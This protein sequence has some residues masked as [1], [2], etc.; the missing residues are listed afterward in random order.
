MV[1]VHILI[2]RTEYRIR[3]TYILRKKQKQRKRWRQRDQ[4][5]QVCFVCPL[6]GA[7]VHLPIFP[8]LLLLLLRIPL[9]STTP[10]PSSSSS[11]EPSPSSLSSML[12][13]SAKFSPLLPHLL[14]LDYISF[15]HFFTTTGKCLFF[16]LIPLAHRCL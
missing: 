8:L 9:S 3:D 1:E 16:H 6:L 12:L 2:I 11:P 4:I 13:S 10:P 14:H 7:V 5:S 15:S